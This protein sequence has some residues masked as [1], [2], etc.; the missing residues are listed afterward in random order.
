MRLCYMHNFL[1]C[2]G[3]RLT[4]CWGIIRYQKNHVLYTSNLKSKMTQKCH[5][6]K[7]ELRIRDPLR[8]GGE[9]KSHRHK[10]PYGGDIIL[11]LIGYLTHRNRLLMFHK[12]V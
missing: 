9:I 2:I 5:R 3:E 10:A 11:A 4:C 1:G 12:Y 8:G 6:G 7:K